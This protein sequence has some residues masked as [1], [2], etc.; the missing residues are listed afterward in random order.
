MM[1]LLAT[2]FDNTLLNNSDYE[3]NIKYINNFVEQG[4]FF[5]IVTGRNVGSLLKDIEK[6]NLKYSYLIC[7]D[8]GIIF[9]KNL[10]II[11][12]KNVSK[13]IIPD[14]VEVFEQNKHLSDWYID[15]GLTITKDK[16]SMANAIVGK[17]FDFDEATKLFE[18]IKDRYHEIDGYV[19]MPWVSI[20]EKTVNKGTGVKYIADLLGI[21]EEN[22]YTIGDN[23]NDLSMSDH[24]FNNYRMINSIP[25]LKDKTIKAY[26][27]VYELVIDIIKDN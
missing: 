19:S 23:I 26:D 9:D 17:T 18:Q 15:T 22:V 16:N 25:T 13:D 21:H 12:Q 1:K 10:K 5:I 3:T 8:G 20:T 2:D 27:A 14:V 4:N 7:N 6:T 11:Y 24:N